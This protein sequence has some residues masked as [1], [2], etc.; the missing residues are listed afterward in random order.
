MECELKWS[1]GRES[2]LGKVMAGRRWNGF[3]HGVAFGG[4][5]LFGPR[6]LLWDF[7][8]L[9][10]RGQTLHS[11][12]RD[13]SEVLEEKVADA[14]PR[15]AQWPYSGICFSLGP[16][17]PQG[18]GPVSSENE[19]LICERKFPNPPGFLHDLDLSK[20]LENVLL[21]L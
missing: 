4:H 9:V 12:F 2:R 21:C 6:T 10:C 1:R 20:Y 17:G 7:S 14:F 15:G 19:L 16:S 3:W 13:L 18:M 11:S 8:I 5:T